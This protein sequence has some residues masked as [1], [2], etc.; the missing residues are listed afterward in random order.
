[1]N[2][3]QVAKR[4]VELC[5]QGRYT[6]AHEELFA[7]DAVNI[8]MEGMPEGPMGGAKGLDAIKQKGR[9]FGEMLEAVHSNEVSEPVV[10]GDWF[11]VAAVMEATMQG[12][13]R[14]TM[15]EICVYH[16][17]DGKIDR[18]QFFYDM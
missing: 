14:V 3:E 12:R 17:R 16:V 10:A 4:L 9:V 11:S 8:E 2:T 1:M 6:D 7:D 18:E 15:R 5:R 13:G